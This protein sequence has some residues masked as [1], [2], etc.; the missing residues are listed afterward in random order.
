MLFHPAASLAC[1]NQQRCATLHNYLSVGLCVHPRHTARMSWMEGSG[2]G[3]ELIEHHD[4][5]SSPLP[6][7]SVPKESCTPINPVIGRQ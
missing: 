6:L 5:Y 2:G 4:C 1:S 7:G 3:S